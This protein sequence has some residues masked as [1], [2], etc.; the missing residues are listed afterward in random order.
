ME[1]RISNNKGCFGGRDEEN[2]EGEISSWNKKRVCKW[3]NKLK[4]FEEIE[5]IKTGLDITI[6][7]IN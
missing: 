3:K 7:F 6:K 2:A 1:T 5:N 4:I